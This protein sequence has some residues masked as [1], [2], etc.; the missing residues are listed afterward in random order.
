MAS[1]LRRANFA[2]GEAVYER[3]EHG[4][5][6]FFVVQGSVV[7]HAAP[8][9]AAPGPRGRMQTHQPPA[10]EQ[11]PGGFGK[12]G[13]TTVA[14]AGER[15]AG[16]GDVFGE[17]GLFSELGM[18]RR[19]NATALSWVSAYVLSAATLLE[20]T[21]K[22]PEVCRRGGVEALTGER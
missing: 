5:E 21:K 16:K 17:G 6:M 15:I 9:A 3:G 18:W 20:I 2:G 8:R 14:A 10:P 11:L 22:Y 12:D 7:L 4:D 1:H 19:E 13:G